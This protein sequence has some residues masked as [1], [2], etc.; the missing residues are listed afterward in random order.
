MSAT[1]LG[2]VSQ[3]REA[4]ERVLIGLFSILAAVHVFVFSAAFP[5][6]NTMDEHSHFDLVVKYSHGHLPRG[7]SQV[8]GTAEPYILAYSSPE[9]IWSPVL[10]P[11]GRYPAPAWI[12]PDR[13][14]SGETQPRAAD[15]PLPFSQQWLEKLKSGPNYESSQQPLYYAVAGL[16]WH[17][18]HWCGFQGLRL[19]YWTRFLNILFVAALVWV[20][21]FTARM[22]FPENLFLRLGVPTLIAFFSQQAFYSIQNDVLSPLCFGLAFICLLRWLRAEPPGLGLG[23]ATGLS[24]AATFLAKMSNLPFLAV[25]ALVVLFKLWQWRGTGKW[26]AALPALAGMILCAA[27]PIG[28]WLAWSK[29]AFG[30]F[31]GMAEKLQIISWTR[32]PFDEWWH[33]PI[34]TPQGCWT[35]VSELLTAFW[36]GEFHWHGQPL[37]LPVVDALYVILSMCFLSLATVKLIPRFSVATRQQRQALWLGLVCFIAG[38]GFLAFLSVIYDFGSCPSP[39]REHPYFIA[40]RLILGALIPFLLLY[41]YGLDCL[42]RRAGNLWLRLAALTV[43]ILFMLISEIIT[44]W[45]VFSSRYNWFHA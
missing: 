23:I 36:Q 5:F 2:P 31:S 26:R 4:K 8:D 18:G 37:D 17:V 29:W 24:L 45:S 10:C 34:F 7:M 12:Q 42:L 41:L 15:K 44:D 9:Y 3:P 1:N 19:L 25:S 16:W 28:S 21:Y 11:G 40:G 32:K 20:G 6:F 22:V 27:L 43:M 33:H 39:S 30:D 14:L 13:A 38:A 35:F